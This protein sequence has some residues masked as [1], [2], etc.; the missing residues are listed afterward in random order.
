[1]TIIIE[2]VIRKRIFNRPVLLIAPTPL[3]MQIAELRAGARRGIMLFGG[4]ILPPE[5]FYLI[6]QHY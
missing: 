5:L 2:K 3:Q 4:R 1:M 6:I